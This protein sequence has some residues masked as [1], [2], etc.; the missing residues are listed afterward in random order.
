MFA[1]KQLN[2]KRGNCFTVKVLRR[3][4]GLDPV[5]YSHS[6]HLESIFLALPINLFF[7]SVFTSSV[8]KT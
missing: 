8:P 1:F 4:F 5:F 6:L 3:K 2:V 7:S